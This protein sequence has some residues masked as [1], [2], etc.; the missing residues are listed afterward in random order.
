VSEASNLARRRLIATY[1]HCL[2]EEG[3]LEEADG[4][5]AADRL[6][7]L[8]PDAAFCS[9]VLAA[10]G[11]LRLAQGDARAALDDLLVCGCRE[12]AWGP[13][14]LLMP[15]YWSSDAAL[16]YAELG[17]REAALALAD[18]AVA[19]A[20]ELGAPGAL[21]VALR[22]AGVVRGQADGFDLLEQA[23]GQ[24][25][26]SESRLELARAL[27][28]LGRALHARDARKEARERLRDA[29][30]LAA[31][32]AAPAL[33]AQ[34]EVRLKEG[35]GRLPRLHVRGVQALTRQERRVA[36][37]AADDMTNRQIAQELYVTEKT[38]ETHL[39]HAYRK[40]TIKSRAELAI[41][42]KSA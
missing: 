13:R 21:G 9:D 11:R 32:C 33:V 1:L 12:R 19:V 20:R 17:E 24:L 28:E 37:L 7:G 31:E 29:R 2:I 30:A 26:A 16:A 27:F 15:H 10:R 14:A 38:V 40:L 22:T 39:S 6:E 23:V 3:A 35:G 4:V 5:L 42:L 8:I 25:Q 34:A 36:E 18:E 41:K